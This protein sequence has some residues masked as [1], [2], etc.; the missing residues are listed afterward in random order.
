MPSVPAKVRLPRAPKLLYQM[1][2]LRRNPTTCLLISSLLASPF[3]EIYNLTLCLPSPSAHRRTPRR[4]LTMLSP[5]NA[6]CPKCLGTR[7]ARSPPSLVSHS[8]APHQHQPVPLPPLTV[9]HSKTSPRRRLRPFPQSR[10]LSA[11]RKC[12]KDRH[13]DRLLSL[14]PLAPS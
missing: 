2:A 10:H 8:L 1:T 6:P 14:I 13:H 7:G 4:T 9:P 12:I 11:A 5:A 3:R